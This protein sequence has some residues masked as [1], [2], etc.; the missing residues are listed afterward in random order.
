MN[1]NK[2][3]ILMVY[4]APYPFIKG[5]GQRRFFEIGKRLAERGWK[6]YW[7][8]FRNWANNDHILFN[9]I[10]YLSLGRPPR[11]FNAHGNRTKLFPIILGGEHSITPG[12]ITPFIKRH[13]TG[14]NANPYRISRF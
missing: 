14:I 7:L 1:I 9:G 5:G 13:N 10:K 3:R 11:V 6:V 12:C 8:T 2:G 4:E